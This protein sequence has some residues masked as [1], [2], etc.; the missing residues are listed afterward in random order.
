MDDA[1]VA[2][3]AT[4]RMDSSIGSLIGFKAAG[5]TIDLLGKEN[6][7]GSPAYTLNVAVKSAVSSTYFLD[8][9]TFLPVK[10]IARVS[11]MEQEVEGETYPGDYK[12]VE[13]ILFAHSMEAHVN[14]QTLRL[15]YDKIEVNVPMDDSLFR[16]PG[17]ETP[18]IKKQDCVRPR[19]KLIPCQF[20]SPREIGGLDFCVSSNRGRLKGNT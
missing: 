12:K 7:N 3:L 8:A 5:A 18:G 2:R 17:T 1:T 4:G 11:M 13:G 16:L 15:N 19:E 10:I 9:G 6:V 20:A 14:G